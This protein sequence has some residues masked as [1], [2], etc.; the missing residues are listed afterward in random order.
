MNEVWLSI[1]AWTQRLLLA[2][3]VIYFALYVYNNSGTSVS[4]WFWFKHE[5]ATTVF[6][7]TSGAFLAGMIFTILV[8][9]ALK[10]LRQIRELRGR[11]RQDKLERDI[12]EM[13]AKAAML[14]TRPIDAGG[15]S[16]ASFSAGSIADGGNTSNLH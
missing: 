9:T 4:F 7:L 13:K 15:T 5:H 16:S 10:T 11:S 1:K 14:Q 12:S 6:F 8:S 3:L 2:A